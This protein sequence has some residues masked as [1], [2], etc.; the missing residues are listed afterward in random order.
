MA[1]SE[2]LKPL[3]PRAR[4]N[5]P[6]RRTERGRQNVVSK[7]CYGLKQYERENANKS[8]LEGQACKYWMEECQQV[9]A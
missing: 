7:R 4:E 2:L 6:K 5:V 3:S 9:S 1:L 8:V